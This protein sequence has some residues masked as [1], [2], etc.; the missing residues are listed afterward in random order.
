MS[1]I[2]DLIANIQAG[3]APDKNATLEDGEE[4]V[5]RGLFIR[6]PEQQMVVCYVRSV[7]DVYC[8]GDKQREWSPLTKRIVSLGVDASSLP[9][10]ERTNKVIAAAILE[11]VLLPKIYL[12]SYEW[13]DAERKMRLRHVLKEPF[14]KG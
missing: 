4:I 11:G 6:H 1:E 7:K 10:R 3:K 14:T 2:D 5:T 8:D 13:L 12:E 9:L